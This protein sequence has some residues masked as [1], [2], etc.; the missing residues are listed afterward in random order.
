[1]FKQILAKK[2]Y[3]PALLNMGHLCFIRND[4]KAALGY[5]QRASA[6]DPKNP[7]VLLA[8][9]RADQDLKNYDDMRQK[10]DQLKELDPKLAEQYSSLGTK[11]ATGSRATD[12][13]TKRLK[14]LW[15]TK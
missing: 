8:I 1:M 15:E 3:L 2:A 4:C 7:H 14:V 5:Y 6:I 13:G 11:S 12:I 9:A 10:Y